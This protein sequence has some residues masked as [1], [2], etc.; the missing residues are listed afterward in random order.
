MASSTVSIGLPTVGE[1]VCGKPKIA[2]TGIHFLPSPESLLLSLELFTPASHPERP[3]LTLSPSFTVSR[4][5]S[6][7]LTELAP[8][9]PEEVDIGLS[10]E[11]VD[12]VEGSLSL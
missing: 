4:P 11:A 12:I 1:I 3:F 6:S 9:L 10:E 7:H 5:S 2:V 8:E